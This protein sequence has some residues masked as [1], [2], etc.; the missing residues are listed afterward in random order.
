MAINL[1]SN[2]PDKDLVYYGNDAIVWDRINAERL[3]RRLPGLAAIGIPK[4]EDSADGTA[5]AGAPLSNF[6]RQLGAPVTSS[7]AQDISNLETRRSQLTKSITNIELAQR[8]NEQSLTRARQ[9]LST[10][11]D[12]QQKA[13]IEKQILTLEAS[14]AAQQSQVSKL[15][16]QFQTVNSDIT[17][18][19][20]SA[21]PNSPA[22]AGLPTPSLPSLPKIPNLST[23]PVQSPV[24]AA[25][26][27]KTVPATVKIPGLDAAQVTGLLGS[28]AKTASSS[29]GIGKFGATPEQ[30]EQQGLLKPGTSKSFLSTPPEITA[31]DQAEADK[32]NASGGS[33]TA[34][35]VARNRKIN[36]VLSSPFSW[37]GKNGVNSLEGF[38]G[39]ETLQSITQQ[40]V[41]GENL[42]K[43]KSLGVVTGNE[44][45]EQLGSLAQSAA[46][47]GPG[48]V[49]AWTKGVASPDV[50]AAINNTAK[51][52]QQAVDLVNKQL[53]SL[54][55][56][57]ANIQGKA[58]V[59]DRSKL[60][61]SFAAVLGDPKISLPA[62]GGAS[63]GRN[64]IS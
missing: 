26:I 51:D 61:S 15:D 25:Q 16:Q 63:A 59:V 40:N 31:Q 58:N 41:M 42:N 29:G 57:P 60:D 10:A 53:P 30:L 52:A 20:R 49:D 28:A 19:L 24:N 13:E 14:I 33:T 46:K 3:R 21:F 56:I 18:S 47:F 36:Q 5:L 35:Q 50:A 8:R 23:L 43:L 12:P 48:A 32:I 22:L 4:P 2:T 38:A 37:T 64:R 45:P 7:Q 39:N 62:F 34:E 6:T 54:G 27:L 11:T 9:S 55:A 44:T 17:S 1:Y